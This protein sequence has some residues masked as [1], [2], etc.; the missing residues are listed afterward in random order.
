MI[1]RFYGIWVSPDMADQ[2]Q[3]PLRERNVVVRV[4]VDSDMVLEYVEKI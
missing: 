3:F 4:F 1:C 2:P